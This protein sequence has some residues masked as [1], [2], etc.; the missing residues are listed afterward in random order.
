MISFPHD[1]DYYHYRFYFKKMKKEY[2]WMLVVILAY[3]VLGLE[4]WVSKNKI[5]IFE[6]DEDLIEQY[7]KKLKKYND[8]KILILDYLIKTQPQSYIRLFIKKNFFLQQ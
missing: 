8:L 4:N 5:Y 2:F 6:P 1:K 3:R 7:L